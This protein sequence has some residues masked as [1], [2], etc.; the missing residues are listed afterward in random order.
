[1]KNLIEIYSKF[2]IEIL[3][4]I[5]FLKYRKTVTSLQERLQTFE[6]TNKTLIEDATVQK[7]H[8]EQLEEELTKAKAEKE[9]IQTSYQAKIDVR[10]KIK[11]NMIHNF[12][13]LGFK[14]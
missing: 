10:F 9:Q 13:Y 1:M 4:L 11:N 2:I 6:Q 5:L 14:C 3:L 12:F 7:I 8:I